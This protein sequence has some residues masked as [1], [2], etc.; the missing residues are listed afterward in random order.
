MGRG[1][2]RAVGPDLIEKAV[3][4]QPSVYYEYIYN[5]PPGHNGP[6]PSTPKWSAVVQGLPA[7]SAIEWKCVKH[8]A[9][10]QWQWQSGANNTVTAPASGFA[11]TSAGAF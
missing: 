11:G 10:G 5:P 7:N 2:R 8:L 6:G 9:S 4:L 3:K 1:E